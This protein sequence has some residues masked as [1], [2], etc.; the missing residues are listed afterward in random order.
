MLHDTLHTFSLILFRIYVSTIRKCGLSRDNICDEP[1]SSLR[2]ISVAFFLLDLISTDQVRSWKLISNFLDS[3]QVRRDGNNYDNDNNDGTWRT[4][5]KTA[6]TT[7]MTRDDD[8]NDDG[9][10]DTINTGSIESPVGI[11]LGPLSVIQRF[12]KSGC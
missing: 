10:D 2:A 9:D 4:L 11:R 12:L 3:C 8:D 6:M 5:T 1:R 7:T